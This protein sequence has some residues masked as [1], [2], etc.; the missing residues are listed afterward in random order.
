M[1]AELRPLVFGL[2]QVAEYPSECP[3]CHYVFAVVISSL[4]G[5]G[6]GY[7]LFRCYKYPVPNGTSLLR[8]SQIRKIFF[9][10]CS[11]VFWIFGFK[12]LL[13]QKSLKWGRVILDLVNNPA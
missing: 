13:L 8:D 1:R 9:L 12:T 7:R 4:T 2:L 3:F 5:L 10:L 11:K 6:E